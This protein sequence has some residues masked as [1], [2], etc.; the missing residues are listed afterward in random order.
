MTKEKKDQVI[1][2]KRKLYEG[3]T[4]EFAAVSTDWER[5]NLTG[6]IYRILNLINGK[7]YIGQT[8]NWFYYRYSSE[9]WDNNIDN[10]LLK[11]AI[12]KYGIENF[13]VQILEFGVGR[14]ETLNILEIKYIADYKT[15]VDDGCGYNLTRG[16]DNRSCSE[17]T[18]QRLSKKYSGENNPQF[19]KTGEKSTWFGK[20]HSLKTRE[21]MSQAQSGENNPN[22]GKITPLKTRKKLSEA[23]MGKKQRPESIAKS[24]AARKIPVNQLDKI[25][26]ELVKTWES[27]TD[28]GRCLSI[29]PGQINQVCKGKLISAGNFKWSYTNPVLALLYPPKK[30]STPG[31]KRKKPVDQLNKDTGELIKTWQSATDAAESLIGKKTCRGQIGRV[32]KGEAKFAGN[33][34]WRYAKDDQ[35]INYID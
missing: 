20:N 4:R 28:A 10:P 9:R 26:R 15:F 5:Q 12:K 14:I 33:F 30:L 25:T 19:G 18:R 16:G 32:C 8:I 3:Y 7:S 35:I 1:R 13:E 29:M 23:N 6:I 17:E 24:V 11:A 31:L 27:A 21:K 2:E 22:F 34:G